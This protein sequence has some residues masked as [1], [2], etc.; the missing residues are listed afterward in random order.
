MSNN[1]HE[2]PEEVYSWSEKADDDLRSAKALLKEEIYGNACGAAEQAVEKTVKAYIVKQAG[3]ITAEE[4]THNL[5]E[6]S[7]RC[8]ELGLDLSAYRDDLRWFSDV[9]VPS[10][11]PIPLNPRF[12]K[13]DA[14]EAIEKAEEIIEFLRQAIFS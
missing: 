4:R 13:Q 14:V 12:S 10:R 6:L 11:Y 3:A 1:N 2:I 9:Y 7:R 8:L 5:V